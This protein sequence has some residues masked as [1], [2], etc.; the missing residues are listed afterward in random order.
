M[1]NFAAI[2]ADRVQA[3]GPLGK[4]ILR[5]AF[6]DVL[7]EPILNRKKMGFEVPVGEFLRN[8]LR[9]DVQ[10]T[11]SRRKALQD[12][13]IRHEAAERLYEAHCRRRGDHTEILWALLVLC[14]WR[15][16]P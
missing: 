6:A 1:V 7:P 10:A 3:A 2:A 15:S 11:W 4:R 9:P 12:F 14:H 8:E 13:G 16:R 5:D